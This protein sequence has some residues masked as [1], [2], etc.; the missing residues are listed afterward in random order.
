[1]RGILA[2][3]ALA[4]DLTLTIKLLLAAIRLLEIIA[5]PGSRYVILIIGIYLKIFINKKPIGCGGG[6]RICR[7]AAVRDSKAENRAPWMSHYVRI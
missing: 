7:Q 3:S 5:K 2:I 4:G 6:G 1:M